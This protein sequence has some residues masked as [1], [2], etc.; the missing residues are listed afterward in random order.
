MTILNDD[1]ISDII[2]DFILELEFKIK[3]KSKS[4]IVQEPLLYI[5]RQ[6]YNISSTSFIKSHFIK[7]IHHLQSLQYI[8][9]NELHF[10]I[11]VE[12]FNTSDDLFKLFTSAAAYGHLKLVEFIIHNTNIIIDY[13]NRDY[14][15][16]TPLNMA[17]QNNHFEIAE[18]LIKNNVQVKY[19]DI[20]QIVSFDKCTLKSFKF[21]LDNYLYPIP[22]E[23]LLEMASR[24]GNYDIVIY[25]VIH[26]HANI[27]SNNALNIACL[28]G[29]LDIVI[30]L[31]EH[32]ADLHNN[33]SALFNAA[34]NGHLDIVKYLIQ[35]GA[36]INEKKN[37]AYIY[38]S[39]HGHLHVVK[40]LL[41]NIKV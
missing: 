3:L 6:F 4:L 21:L 40:Y 23:M 38:A 2:L 14:L 11:L 34:S 19:S 7:S 12:H 18:Y 20:R 29:H 31:I 16:T 13:N 32:G 35:N 26:L 25:L 30:F 39:K 15:V 22:S 24:N 10:Y 36:I 27:H 37:N 28:N 17:L 1:I 33:K 41:D 8:D 9:V 5:S